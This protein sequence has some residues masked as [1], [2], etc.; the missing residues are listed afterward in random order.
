[1]KFASLLERATVPTTQAA[2]A[3]LAFSVPISVALDNLLLAVLLLFG[4][5]GVARVAVI[6]A[7]VNPVARA[8]WLL[9]G[10]LFIATLYG[11]TPWSEALGT[12]GKYG[13]L[14]FLPLFMVAVS[15]GGAT[16]FA[17]PLFMLA[18]A[19]TLVLS[20]MVGLGLIGVQ[21]W[22]WAGIETDNPAIFHSSITQNLLMG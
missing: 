10:M 9:F 17:V 5:V 11:D 8:A 15:R 21:H 12:L 22:M 16:R 18:M 3:L 20:C 1:M 13:D 7:I 19:L 2:I 6:E 4:L 14:A